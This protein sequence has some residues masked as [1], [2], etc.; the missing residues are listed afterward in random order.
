MTEPFL[1]TNSFLTTVKTCPRKAY[2]AYI[3]YGNGIKKVR[4]NDAL[5]VG[6]AVHEAIDQFVKAK[7]RGVTDQAELQKVAM[8]AGVERFNL[9]YAPDVDESWFVDRER[10]RAIVWAYVHRWWRA[11]HDVEWVQSESVLESKII[12]P[13]T[14]RAIRDYLATGKIDKLFRKDGK[15]VLRDHKTTSEQIHPGA[16]YWRRLI[17]DSQISHYVLTL[18]RMGIIV[19]EVEYDV[20]RKPLIKPKKLSPKETQEVIDEQKYRG[21]TVRA[22]LDG[23]RLWVDGERCVTNRSVA[24]FSV[25]ENYRMFFLRLCQELLSNDGQSRYFVRDV[26]PRMA[27]TLSDYGQDLYDSTKLVHEMRKTQR[28][29]MNTSQCTKFGECEFFRVCTAG[30]GVDTTFE[31][32]HSVNTNMAKKESPHEELQEVET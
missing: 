1:I 22:R 27:S 4:R 7:M 13:D 17:I 3:A 15:L 9:T 6:D 16:N 25:Q 29:P 21:Y 14:D 26:V 11:D 31:E 8:D 10:I 30:F 20:I 32:L 28:W 5:S 24:K 19:D 12:N 2:W 18:A 23:D